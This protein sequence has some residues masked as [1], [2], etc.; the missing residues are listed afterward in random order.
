MQRISKTLQILDILS[1]GSLQLVFL[2]SDKFSKALWYPQL[3]KFQG[4]PIH[5]IVNK[6]IR[7]SFIVWFFPPLQ[8]TRFVR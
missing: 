2:S 5:T 7:C 6:L 1:N 8:L 3:E 4:I